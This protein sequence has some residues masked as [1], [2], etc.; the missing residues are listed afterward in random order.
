MSWN[1]LPCIKY[2]G[3]IDPL[4]YG[5]IH[6]TD[7]FDMAHRVV[8]EQASGPIPEGLEI[9]HLCRNRSCVQIHHLEVVTHQENCQRRPKKTQCPQGHALDERNTYVDHRG[10]RRC[11]KCLAAYGRKARKRRKEATDGN[12]QNS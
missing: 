9:D 10:H 3:Y 1:D 6:R 12:P 8:Y 2:D 11:R 5:R 4:G 7:S